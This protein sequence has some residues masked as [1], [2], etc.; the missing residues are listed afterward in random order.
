VPPRHVPPGCSHERLALAAPSLALGQGLQK[1]SERG[2][3]RRGQEHFR[4]GRQG[5]SVSRLSGT[6]STD[7]GVFDEAVALERGELRTDRIIC[8][9]QRTRELLDRARMAAEKSD[10]SPAG[11]FHKSLRPATQHRSLFRT[12]AAIGYLK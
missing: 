10:N 2:T 9:T 11:A 1:A 5:I 7:N 3:V 12:L 4:L 8:Q 6:P